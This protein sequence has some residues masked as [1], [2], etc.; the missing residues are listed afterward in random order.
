VRFLAIVKL[1]ALVKANLDGLVEEKSSFELKIKE[2]TEGF[3]LKVKEI[4]ESID[5]RVSEE[6]EKKNLE[7]SAKLVELEAE[8][9]EFYRKKIESIEASHKEFIEIV[10]NDFIAQTSQLTQV[11]MAEYI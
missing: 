11:I 1:L 4:R 7:F 2:V 10:K 6:L 5:V 3:E 9:D 8:K